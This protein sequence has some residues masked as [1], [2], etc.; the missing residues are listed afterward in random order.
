MVF[1]LKLVPLSLLFAQTSG[2]TLLELSLVPDLIRFKHSFASFSQVII[3]ISMV[4]RAIIIN[5]R[6]LPL[7]ISIA[8]MP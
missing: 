7:S 5:K 1:T 3:K 6:A 8:K 2:V 4:V